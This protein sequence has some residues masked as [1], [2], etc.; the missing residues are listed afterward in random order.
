MM[1][2]PLPPIIL[3]IDED[4][5]FTYLIE[6]YALGCGCRCIRAEDADRTLLLAQL[7]R[8][9][10]IVL[11]V[12]THAASGRQLVQRLKAERATHDIPIVICSAVVDGV[13]IWEE[14]ADYFL[15]KPV[16]YD[17]FVATL[18]KARVSL[19]QE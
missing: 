7:E 6:R 19:R 15:G 2:A 4:P 18:A 17:D 3:V 5:Q 10:L 16:M 8:P 9:A 12:A 11:D 1:I 13:R 14:G